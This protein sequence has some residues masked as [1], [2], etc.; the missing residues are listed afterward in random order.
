LEARVWRRKVGSRGQK[1]RATGKRG[2]RVW[3]P[4]ICDNLFPEHEYNPVAET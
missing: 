3:V 2:D 1:Q 4:Q